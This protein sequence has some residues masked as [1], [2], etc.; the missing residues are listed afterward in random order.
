VRSII[1]IVRWLE[2][3]A[4]VMLLTA[5]GAMADSLAVQG[6]NAAG[7][8]DVKLYQNYNDINFGGSQTL[9]IL[10]SSGFNRRVLFKFTNL[11][12][13]GTDQVIDS[14]AIDL[15][16]TSQSGATLGMFEMWKDWYEG[17]SDNAV[18]SGAVDDNH[19]CHA[20][21]SWTKEMAD[22]TNDAGS[23]NRGN[24]TGADRKASAMATVTVS[25]ASTWHR[26]RVNAGLAQDWYDGTKQPYG[27]IFIETGAGSTTVF[28][29]S[30]CTTSAY[31][32]KVTIYYH[33]VETLAVSRRRAMM[34]T[35]NQ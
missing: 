25:S 8:Y 28:A 32:P 12:T 22:S 7:I 6:Q 21:S 4:V 14:M 33:A 18:E 1:A 10:N 29:S 24:G 11:D 15:Y 30:E 2:A 35:S 16:C 34:L 9:T 26:F 17:N 5:S 27:V 31:R 19:W 20:D 23:Q 3:V 13:V